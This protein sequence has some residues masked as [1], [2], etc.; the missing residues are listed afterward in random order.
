MCGAGDFCSGAMSALQPIQPRSLGWVGED[1][2][3]QC[4][5]LRC[6]LAPAV[7]LEDGEEV[8]R[9]LFSMPPWLG[10]GSRILS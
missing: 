7:L 9:G 2:A 10:E 4:W 8:A 1:V 3:Q 6:P 5:V